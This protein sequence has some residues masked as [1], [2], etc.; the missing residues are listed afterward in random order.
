M[1]GQKRPE[2][3]TTKRGIT[4]EIKRDRQK[5]RLERKTNNNDDLM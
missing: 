3:S 1:H 5:A 2:R 4:E